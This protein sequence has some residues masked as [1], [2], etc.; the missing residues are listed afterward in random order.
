MLCAFPLLAGAADRRA[1][2]VHDGIERGYLLHVPASVDAARPLP[3]VVVLHGG[4][5]TGARMVRLTSGGFNALA[6]RDGFLVAYPD[7]LEK[8]WNDGRAGTRWRAHRDGVDDVGFLAALI[9]RLASEWPVDARRVYVTG[10]SNGGMMAIR[11]GCELA[12][13]IAAIAPVIG[14]MPETLAPHCAPSAPLAV[15]FMNGVRDPLVPWQG[16]EIRF[17]RKNIGTVLSVAES[18]RFWVTH[19]RCAVTPVV[20]DEP[21]RDPRDGTRVRRESYASC[22]DGSEVLLYAIEGG[23]H[24]WPGGYQYRPER[25]IGKGSRD[26][27]GAEVI[28]NFFKRQAKPQTGLV[29]P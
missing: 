9:D 14:A 24:T 3:L 11:M 10:A 28:W 27:D 18:V 7:G 23:G 6:D 15:L 5:G 4:G 12:D 20:T 21:D 8:H 1:V 19:N 17:G 22:R 16:G 2:L 13:R 29:L 26:L 25:V